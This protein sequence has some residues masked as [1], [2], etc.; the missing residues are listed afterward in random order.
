MK[1]GPDAAGMPTSTVDTS[2][3][4]IVPAI[5]V[6]A[7]FATQSPVR[8][9]LDGFGAKHDWELS[10]LTEDAKAPDE[11]SWRMCNPGAAPLNSDNFIWTPVM[12]RALSKR[13][14]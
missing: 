7:T 8:E 13:K 5:S 14:S 10:E 3:V 2:T 4:C 12:A 9:A 1:L 6:F 11:R